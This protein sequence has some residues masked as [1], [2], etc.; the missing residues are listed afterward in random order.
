ML[1]TDMVAEP[2]K[3]PTKTGLNE[4]TCEELRKMCKKHS[5]ETGGVKS[6]LVTRLLKHKDVKLKASAAVQKDVVKPKS[7]KSG[8]QSQTPKLRAPSV[9]PSDPT[10]EQFSTW[11]REYAYWRKTMEG[12]HADS[13]LTQCLLTALP[14][15]AKK[16]LFTELDVDSVSLTSVLEILQAEFGDDEFLEKRDALSHYR[17]CQ[18]TASEGLT[19]FLKRHRHSRQAAMLAGVLVANSATDTWDLLDACQLSSTQRANVTAQLQVRLDMMPESDEFAECQKLLV[20]LARA[21]G[22]ELGDKAKSSTAL[23]SLDG[24]KGG[25]GGGDQSL[26]GAGWQKFG[27]NWKR[28]GKGSKGG[29]KGKSKGAGKSS[30][31]SWG[32]NWNAGKDWSAGKSAGKGFG[33]G[34]KDYKNKDWVCPS[35]EARCWGSKDKCF[36]CGT[37]KPAASV[38]AST[39]K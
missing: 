39:G 31:K 36:K 37:E 3:I 20:N 27:G 5:L 7:E 14:D 35:C 30:G 9:L 11:K 15:T 13:A 12:H 4:K 26:A 1:A 22:K 28:P 8:E 24:G 10:P 19:E 33:K 17:K 21:F 23:F 18:R 34:G 16:V 6:A 25:G 2:P 38:P 32:K 29:G